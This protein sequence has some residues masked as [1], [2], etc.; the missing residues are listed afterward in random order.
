MTKED[1][2]KKYV[3]EQSEIHIPN[4]G[5]YRVFRKG[6]SFYSFH[7]FDT[8][9]GESRKDYENFDVLWN[10]EINGKRV[11]DLVKDYEE[12]YLDDTYNKEEFEKNGILFG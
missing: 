1:F 8:R 4:T 6:N 9:T 7:E 2:I 3:D 10:A 12:Y 5:H 11:S